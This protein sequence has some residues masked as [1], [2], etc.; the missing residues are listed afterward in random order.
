MIRWLAK[1][2]RKS[3]LCRRRHNHEYADVFVMPMSGRNSSQLG[4]IAA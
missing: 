1:V 4:L 3:W 2:W